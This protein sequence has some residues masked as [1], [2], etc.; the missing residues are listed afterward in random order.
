MFSENTN[1][2]DF[3]TGGATAMK[4]DASHNI[5]IANKV[6]SYNGVST[7]GWGTPAIYAAGRVTAQ[8]AAAAA[9]STYTV[10]AADGSFI[11]SA[12]VN[13]TAATTAS[14]TCTCTYTDETNTS[15][16]LTLNFSNITGTLLTT[17][18]NV[19]GTGAYEGVPL[20]IRAKASTAITFA[21]VGTF[22][23]VT[24]NA[25]GVIQQIA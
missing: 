7:A 10:G 17:I 4:I 22:T 14:F 19:T 3:S 13:V 5:T 8:T 9:F 16:T 23:S 2:L 1:I 24:Y 15:R 11:V 18:T 12:N 20:H 25:E 6:V 21:T